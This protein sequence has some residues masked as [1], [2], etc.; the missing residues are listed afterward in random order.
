[1][2]VKGKGN[3]DIRMLVEIHLHRDH[4]NRHT[5]SGAVVAD[6]WCMVVYKY[7]WDSATFLNHG[8]GQVLVPL[9]YA[10]S[11]AWFSY[12][13]SNWL[14]PC[15]IQTYYSEVQVHRPPI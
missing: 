12:S 9:I 13:M 2:I 4:N 6:R 8:V 15:C 11:M 10:A 14:L 5:R 7:L 3:L 1:M